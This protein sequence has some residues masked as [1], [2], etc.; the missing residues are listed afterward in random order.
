MPLPI[1]EPSFWIGLP[2][3]ILSGV[4]LRNYM[5]GLKEKR[6]GLINAIKSLEAKKPH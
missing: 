3:A 5:R 6:N 2:F 1:F 4:V